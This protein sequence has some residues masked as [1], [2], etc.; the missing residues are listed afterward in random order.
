MDGVDLGVRLRRQE[1]VDVVGG[2]AFFDLPDRCP[3]GPDAGEAGEG[4][5]VI[6][7]EPDIAAFGPVELAE[8]VERHHAA[9]LDADGP[10]RVY[11]ENG[12]LWW[13]VGPGGQDLDRLLSSLRRG[14]RDANTSQAKGRV[15]R[16]H[17]TLQDRQTCEARS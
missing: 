6:Q 4:A 9:A 5:R 1:R 12:S 7:R 17:H 8:G 10:I 14:Y 13:P 11:L 15:E 16:A 2:L 3:V